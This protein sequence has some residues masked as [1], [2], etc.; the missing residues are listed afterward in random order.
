MRQPASVQESCTDGLTSLLRHSRRT[1]SN[2][3]SDDDEIGLYLTDGMS[4]LFFYSSDYF[5][6]LQANIYI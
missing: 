3:I 6:D 1:N 2:I 4:D 5:S